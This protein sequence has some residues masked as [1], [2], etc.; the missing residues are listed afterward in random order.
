MEHALRTSSGD[1]RQMPT[2]SSPKLGVMICSLNIG[3]IAP[4]RDSAQTR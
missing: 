1:L 3:E 2:A 4:L